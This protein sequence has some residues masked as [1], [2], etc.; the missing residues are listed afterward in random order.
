VV[1][2]CVTVQNQIQV[3]NELWLKWGCTNPAPAPAP[4]PAPPD[5][6]LEAKCTYCDTVLDDGENVWGSS[7]GVGTVVWDEPDDV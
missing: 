3:L 2:A 5:M 4:A 1:R 7:C 6:G